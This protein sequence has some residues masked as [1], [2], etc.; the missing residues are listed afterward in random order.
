M[1][2]TNIFYVYCYID[3]RDNIPFYVGKGKNTRYL[4]HLSEATN[5]KKHNSKVFK[6][7]EITSEGL[8]PTIIK[9][10][11]NL[12][13]EYAFDLEIKLIAELGRLDS[14]TGVLCNRT[15]GGE[16]VSGHSQGP[17][18]E[19]RKLKNSLYSKNIHW[20]EERKLKLSNDRTGE[21][22]PMYGKHHTEAYKSILVSRLKD[23][24]NDMELQ[25]A[26]IQKTINTWDI[27]KRINSSSDMKNYTSIKDTSKENNHFYGKSHT[28]ESK[29]K[30]RLTSIN[31]KRPI[32]Y[33]VI[34][35]ENIS[36]LEK[37]LNISRNL[38]RGLLIKFPDEI[39]Y[40][41]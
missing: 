40:A 14:G 39:S 3:P 36:K 6:I 7:R 30:F 32:Y 21:G 13:E 17:L 29:E 15:D 16:G 12:S 34:L 18:S 11:E 19:E 8:T 27:D 23:M 26:K 37:V 9:I 38:I 20:T 10:E 25:K 33:K 41:D 1:N 24:Y 5:K 28:E 35:Y 22:N 2:D 4:D 31:N